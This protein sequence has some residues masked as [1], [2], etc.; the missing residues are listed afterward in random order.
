SEIF[1]R[2]PRERRVPKYNAANKMGVM[3]VE[4]GELTLIMITRI[5]DDLSSPDEAYTDINLYFGN[6][7]N[8]RQVNINLQQVYGEN[9]WTWEDETPTDLKAEGVQGALARRRAWLE[10]I[11]AHLIIGSTLTNDR[12]LWLIGQMVEF[13][14]LDELQA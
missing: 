10:K 8:A 2:L 5:P 14:Q 1:Y 6:T 4:K 13:M 3:M 12:A 11:E 9:H 7:V